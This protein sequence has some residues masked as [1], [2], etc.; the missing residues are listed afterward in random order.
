MEIVIFEDGKLARGQKAKL[1]KRSNKRVLIEFLYDDFIEEKIIRAW[2]D[3][4]TRFGG[5]KHNNKRKKASY[6]HSESNMFYSDFYQTNEYKKEVKEYISTE[7][8][9]ELFKIQWSK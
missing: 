8:Y 6:C 7:Y 5:V 9:N 3:M 2:F 1:I 4:F